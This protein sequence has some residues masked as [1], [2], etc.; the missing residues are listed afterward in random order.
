MQQPVKKIQRYCIINCLRDI[1]LE[2]LWREEEGGI[3]KNAQ[4]K[5]VHIRC[6][7]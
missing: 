5:I 3:P 2:S 4:G 7:K 1:P 6:E